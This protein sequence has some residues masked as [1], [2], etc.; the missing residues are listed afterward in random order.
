MSAKSDKTRKDHCSRMRCENF[1][2]PEGDSM[3]GSISLAAAVAAVL[4]GG[5]LVD[6]AQA[7]GYPYCAI[8]GGAAGYETCNYTWDQCMAA[9]SAVGG[10][11][12]PNPRFRPYSGYEDQQPRRRKVRRRQGSAG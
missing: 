9:V 6:R 2:P 10:Y 3:R 4:T 5:M 8:Q 12:Q 1:T 7:Q 11:C